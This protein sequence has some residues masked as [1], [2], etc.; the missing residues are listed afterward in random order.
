MNNQTI[1]DQ[2]S[3]INTFY[4]PRMQ[5]CIVTSRSRCVLTLMGRQVFFRQKE[6]CRTFG[7]HEGPKLTCFHSL[8]HIKMP[9]VNSKSGFLCNMTCTGRR[10]KREW[11]KELKEG[12][13]ENSLFCQCF[14]H[15]GW[16]IAAVT[17]ATPAG[18]R[19]Q[20]QC[21]C[22]CSNGS[23]QR[24][25]E[26]EQKISLLRNNQAF[27]HWHRCDSAHRKC[28]HELSCNCI[29]HCG[30]TCSLLRVSFCILFCTIFLSHCY[31]NVIVL[32]IPLAILFVLSSKIK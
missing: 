13:K 30:N 6:N 7:S 4:I 21:L 9:Q 28:E 22:E 2:S 5:Y 23:E 18:H 15:T 11:K 26:A 14:H 32:L 16:V 27:A 17:I 31:L 24:D 8:I 29:F 19:V 3:S 20:L 1:F 12:R 10:K 25:W